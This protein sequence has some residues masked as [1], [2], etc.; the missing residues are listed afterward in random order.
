ME[1]YAEEAGLQVVRREKYTS[2][3]KDF[4]AQMLSLKNTKAEIMVVYSTNAE[5]AGTIERQYRELG[6]P[7]SY[8]GSPASQV[9]IAINLSGGA[10]EGL[11]A[12]IH[13]AYRSDVPLLVS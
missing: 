11:V 5:D 12:V 1:K 3:D 4:T 6:S 9:K 10:A 7:F 13:N 8:I 2:R